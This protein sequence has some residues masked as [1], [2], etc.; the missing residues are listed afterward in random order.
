M[1]ITWKTTE[2]VENAN[3]INEI[4]IRMT[5]TSADALERIEEGLEQVRDTE[6]QEMNRSKH[7][8][9]RKDGSINMADAT[10]YDWDDGTY[11]GVLVLQLIGVKNETYKTRVGQMLDLTQTGMEKDNDI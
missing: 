11:T 10:L 7:P 5:N 9:T 4:H 8:S 6:Y 3:Q 1:T 2:R